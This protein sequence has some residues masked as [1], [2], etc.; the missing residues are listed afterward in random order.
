MGVTLK[1]DWKKFEKSLHKLAN[2]NYTA[3][4]KEIGEELLSSTQERFK[5]QKGPDGKSWPK[6]RRA[7][8]EK[9]QTLSDTRDLRNS[10]TV[11]ASPKK[12][13]VG[14]NKR[15]AV[16]HQKGKTIKARRKKYLKFKVGSQWVQKK[17]VKIPKRPFVG[18]SKEDRQEV[19]EIIREHIQGA[20]EK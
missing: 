11:K 13:E 19:R 15:Y 2:I 3:L 20:I 7:Q 1:G 14:T 4:H 6:S 5:T 18:I 10:I 17:Q 16:T 8:N 9:G 12:A